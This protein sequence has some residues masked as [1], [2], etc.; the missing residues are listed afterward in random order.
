MMTVV[1]RAFQGA[2]AAVGGVRDLIAAWQ[3]D[4]V[5][6]PFDLARG[7]AACGEVARKWRPNST[8]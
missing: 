4:D 2:E 8:G 1:D 5:S 3:R 6:T 7:H